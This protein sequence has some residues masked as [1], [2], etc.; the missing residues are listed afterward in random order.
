MIARIAIV[1]PQEVIEV[2][3]LLGADIVPALTAADA[4][5]E[6]FRLKKETQKDEN[7]IERPAYGI[8]FV[9][10]DFMSKYT[11]DEEKKI[12]RG[13]LPAV[14]ALPSHSASTG[15]SMQR[16][17]RIVERAIGSDILK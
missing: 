3:S 8:I 17:K 14:I 15:Y 6:I 10:E 7:N 5:V 13:A 11:P 4:L 2:F 16:L 1:G 9:S 12:A